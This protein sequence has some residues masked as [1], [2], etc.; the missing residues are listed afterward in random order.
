MARVEIVDSAHSVARRRKL[1]AA[2]AGPSPA[3]ADG[4]G[5]RSPVRPM[6]VQRVRL[7]S[8]AKVALAFWSCIGILMVGATLTTWV[9]LSAAGAVTNF[10]K[11]VKDMTGVKEF[12][13]LSGTILTAIILLICLFV[14]VASACTVIAA[15]FYN[16]VSSTIGGIEVVAVETGEEVVGL[17]Q[18]PEVVRSNGHSDGPVVLKS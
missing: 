15:A 18:Q 1:R 9:L 8:V 16:V 11:F 13:V 17:A 6:V 3:P 2:H 10:E 14:L 7:W 5:A 12:H 4:G